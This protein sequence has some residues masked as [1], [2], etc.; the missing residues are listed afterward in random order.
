MTDKKDLYIIIGGLESL[1]KNLTQL[2]QN[3]IYEVNNIKSL[4]NSSESNNSGKKISKIELPNYARTFYE[5]YLVK[6]L[7]NHKELTKREIKIECELR[8][9]KLTYSA[10]T[11]YLT[12]LVKYKYLIS[13]KNPKKKS[14]MLYKLN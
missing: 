13:R 3:L 12:N 10:I 7:N 11:K 14:E 8:G 5:N 9:K 4:I 6:I 1:C 2:S